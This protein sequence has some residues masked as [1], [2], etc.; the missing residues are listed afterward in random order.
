MP[1]IAD[2]TRAL[3]GISFGYEDLGVDTKKARKMFNIM[4][5]QTV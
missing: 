2:G 5:L 1:E 3:F 4:L